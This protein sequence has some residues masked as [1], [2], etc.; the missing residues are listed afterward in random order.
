MKVAPGTTP[1]KHGDD[2]AIASFKPL[3]AVGFFTPFA[4]MCLHCDLASGT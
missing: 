1:I 2:M 3:S 4:T